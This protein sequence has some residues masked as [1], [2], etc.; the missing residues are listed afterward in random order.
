MPCEDHGEFWYNENQ[1][2]KGYGTIARE[3]YNLSEIDRQNDDEKT[4]AQKKK[5]FEKLR[6]H[7]RNTIEAYKQKQLKQT[8]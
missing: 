2:G 7:V 5:K 8:A 1:A 6:N 4:K 3:Y